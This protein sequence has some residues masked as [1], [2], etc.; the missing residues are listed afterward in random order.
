MELGAVCPS[1]T[2]GRVAGRPSLP[3]D[4]PAR[5]HDDVAPGAVGPRF[6]VRMI[7]RYEGRG[8]APDR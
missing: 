4:F 7:E 1:L 2:G 3:A 5:L 8:V 6:F